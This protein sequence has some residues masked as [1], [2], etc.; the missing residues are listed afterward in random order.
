MAATLAANFAAM[1][2]GG[3]TG[4]GALHM[5]HAAKGAACGVL[6]NEVSVANTAPKALARK[7]P[8][9]QLS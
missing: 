5:G 9:Q 3:N 7:L 4:A 6:V 2:R 1:C 8:P